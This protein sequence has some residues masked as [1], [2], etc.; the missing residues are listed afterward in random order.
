MTVRPT[1]WMFGAA[2]VIIGAIGGL[3]LAGAVADA[4]QS[5]RAEAAPAAS[6]PPQRV[7]PT[8]RADVVA[9]YAPLVKRVSP[10]VVNIYTQRV[11]KSRM[12]DDPFFRFFFGQGGPGAGR[13]RVERSL[14]SG[15]I[16][17]SEGLVMTNNHVIDGADQ[18]IVVLS[19]RREFPAR[20]AFADPGS[21]LAV[22]RFDPGPRGVPALAIGDSD[23]VEVG[24]IVLAI[25]NPLGL[26]Q[27]VTSGIVSAIARTGT[28]IN[29]FDFF[30]QT[31]ASINPGNSGGALVSMTGELIGIN[32]AIFSRSGTSSGIGFA[33]P[34]NMV[35]TVL[36]ATTTGR[37][38]R[39]WLGAEGQPVTADTAPALG[40]DRPVGVLVN[41][42]SPNSP[43]ARAGIRAGDVVFAV[44]GREVAD[45]E[46][47]RA[48]VATKGV[49][50]KAILTVIRDRKS[51]N[52]TVDLV[53]PPEVP[54]R[55]VTDLR[56]NHLLA[57]VQ[58]ANLSPALSAELGRGLPDR[59]V[60]VLQMAQGAPA[61][62]LRLLQ[63]G[64]VLLAIN[65]TAVRS[66]DELQRMLPRQITAMSF[67]FARGGQT[68]ECGFQPPSNVFCRQ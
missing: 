60:V 52:I 54:P 15:V 46:S 33:V 40:L 59:G 4:Q 45:I 44:D 17:R 55:D 43:M 48:R 27:T 53:A 49:G 20:L 3:W 7:V 39:P 13:D 14:G 29:D 16:V 9:S 35:R 24:D 67:R 30:L 68:A 23:K 64:D 18:I 28:G 51:Q 57:G 66:V 1:A 56:G 62:R 38:V 25:G 61:A 50:G 11:V 41:T 47:L 22:L 10:A 31:D 42:I 19:D 26:N 32:T 2:L 63:P 6:A 37:L 8:S 5:N 36:N 65:G 12:M 58:V 34:S 21:D